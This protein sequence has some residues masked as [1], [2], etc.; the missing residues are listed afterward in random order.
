MKNQ[1]NCMPAGDYFIPAIELKSEEARVLNKYGRMHRVFCR[2]IIRY[3][4]MTWC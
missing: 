3:C 2:N 1:K 4:L